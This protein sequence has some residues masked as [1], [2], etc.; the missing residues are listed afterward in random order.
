MG[1]LRHRLGRHLLIRPELVRAVMGA[2]PD[3]A[4]VFERSLKAIAQVSELPPAELLLPRETEEEGDPVQCAF[5]DSAWVG[6]MPQLQTLPAS[7]EKQEDWDPSSSSRESVMELSG[8]FF[9]V[10]LTGDS[11][12]RNVCCHGH[13][14]DILETE[15]GAVFDPWVGEL[16]VG[17][18]EPEELNPLVLGWR[19]YA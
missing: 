19:R 6:K 17:F 5:C 11:P 14:I 7:V 10:S 12:L 9:R 13:V 18:L 16:A 1:F 4:A 15:R 3:F 2:G 8:E